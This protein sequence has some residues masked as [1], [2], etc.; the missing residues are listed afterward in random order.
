MAIPVPQNTLR[1]PVHTFDKSSLIISFLLSDLRNVFVHWN[2]ARPTNV[3]LNSRLL[4]Q[5]IKKSQEDRS[6]LHAGCG[7]A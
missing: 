5:F 3:V 4:G 2:I 7:K 6:R 1:G